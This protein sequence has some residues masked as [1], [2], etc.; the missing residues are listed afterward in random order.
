M[1]ELEY[2]SVLQVYRIIVGDEV[3]VTG[4]DNR[5]EALAYAEQL[6]GMYDG[7]EG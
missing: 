1:F 7:M 5:Q 6:L 3:I 4:T 2:D